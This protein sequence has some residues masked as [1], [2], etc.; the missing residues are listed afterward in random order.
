[1]SDL[2]ASFYRAE[3]AWLNP[4][5][6]TPEYDEWAEAQEEKKNLLKKAD[7][8]IELLPAAGL[9]SY[10]ELDEAIGTISGVLDRLKPLLDE[11]GNLIEAFPDEEPDPDMAYD[12]SFIGGEE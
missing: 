2:P 7:D 4:P 1:M 3:S 12:D 11:L 6:T 5:E 8:I 10:D 9:S